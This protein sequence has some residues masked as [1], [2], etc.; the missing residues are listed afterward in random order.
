VGEGQWGRV[1]HLLQVRFNVDS[2]L[3]VELLQRVDCEASQHEDGH[4]YDHHSGAHD[5]PLVAILVREDIGE[6][7]GHCPSQTREEDLQ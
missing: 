6:S 7:V 1:P 5:E 3:E 4:E 2:G